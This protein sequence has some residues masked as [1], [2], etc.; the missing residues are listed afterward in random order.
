MHIYSSAKA[1]FNCHSDLQ[2]D[3]GCGW[4]LPTHVAI[5]LI[6]LSQLNRSSVLKEQKILIL[7]TYIWKF[8]YCQQI[9]ENS[10]IGNIYLK[11]LIYCKRDLQ[12][13][14]VVLGA[15]TRDIWLRLKITVVYGALRPRQFVSMLPSIIKHWIFCMLY[16]FIIIYIMIA[17]QLIYLLTQ[18]ENY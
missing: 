13:V 6:N 17:W 5:D 12:I 3:R 15:Q 14:V 18:E 9:S 11:I 4:R 2:P 16:F 8:W 1:I 10:G 7:P